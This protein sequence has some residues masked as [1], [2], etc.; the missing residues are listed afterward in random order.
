MAELADKKD[1]VLGMIAEDLNSREISE[2][3]G[4]SVR[5]IA[6]I[7]AHVKMGTYGSA[8]DGTEEVVAEALEA[9]FGLELDLQ[10]ALRSNIEQLEPGL[11]I[12]DGGKE[13]SVPSGRIDI[14]AKDR[15]GANVVIEL[16]A[17][18]A[19]RD[20]IGQVLSYMGDSATNENGPVRGILV[21]GDFS[22]RAISA[23]RA[24]PNLEL[25][26]YSFRFSFEPVAR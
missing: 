17:G 6:A 16:K 8:A 23:A 15:D 24:V 4:L 21:A 14:A 12:V 1:V 9:T 18:K 7:R 3:T 2:K 20:A 25:K 10:R 11:I 13:K 5:T 19:D 26:K 22:V